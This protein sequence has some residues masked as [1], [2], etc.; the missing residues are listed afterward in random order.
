MA[1]AMTDTG[2]GGAAVVPKVAVV[3]SDTVP[4]VVPGALWIGVQKGL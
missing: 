3:A 4:D 2:V 1:R